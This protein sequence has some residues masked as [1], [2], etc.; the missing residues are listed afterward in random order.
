MP[1]GPRAPR[2]PVYRKLSKSI[3][4]V[5][6]R[7]PTEIPGYA[8]GTRVSERESQSKYLPELVSQGGR[9]SE[10]EI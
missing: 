8:R 10:L 3:P 9:E 5:S 1:E 7:D 6:P 2:G 4:K